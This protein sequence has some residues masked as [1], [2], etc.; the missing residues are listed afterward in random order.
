ML[1]TQ[2][3]VNVNPFSFSVSILW[4]R[5]LANIDILPLESNIFLLIFIFEF[6]L[7]NIEPIVGRIH[8]E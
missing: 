4:Y 8:F 6:L 7:F 2:L 5:V 1:I 3:F